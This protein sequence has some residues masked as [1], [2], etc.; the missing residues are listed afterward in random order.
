MIRGLLNFRRP[1]HT[2]LPDMAAVMRLDMQRSWHISRMVESQNSVNIGQ[3]HEMLTT[4][5]VTISSLP[6][7]FRN[8]HGGMKHD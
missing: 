3:R 4:S 6:A 8:L 5:I 7:D 2:E 1:V